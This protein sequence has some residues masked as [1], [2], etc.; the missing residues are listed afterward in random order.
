VRLTTAGSTDWRY[1]MLED[2]IPAGTEAVR[3]DDL[4]KLEQLKQWWWGSQRE[5]RDNRVVF[6]QESFESGRYQF[7]YLL[8]VVTPGVFRT[9]PARISAMYVPEGTASSAAITLTVESPGS[10][11]ASTPG[12]GGKQ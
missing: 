5:Y 11:P 12:N 4:Y 2:P 8:K 6:F 10:K 3:Q 7:S 1:L 9:P